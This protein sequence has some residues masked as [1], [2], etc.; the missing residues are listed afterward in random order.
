MNFHVLKGIKVHFFNANVRST[1]LKAE[2]WLFKWKDAR[3][4]R[5]DGLF[6]PKVRQKVGIR[7]EGKMK[8]EK[9]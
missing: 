2:S 4:R 6:D 3:K 7:K 8:Y 5:Y 1:Y 9:C